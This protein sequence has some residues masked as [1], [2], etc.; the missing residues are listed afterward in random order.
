MSSQTNSASQS[1]HKCII[2]IFIAVLS[3]S[4]VAQTDAAMQLYGRQTVSQ[5]D[6]RIMLYTLSLSHTHSAS[7]AHSALSSDS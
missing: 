6:R 7:L 5:L 4:H 1:D 3:G 2:I